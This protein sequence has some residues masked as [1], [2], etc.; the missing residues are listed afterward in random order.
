MTFDKPTDAVTRRHT[1]R[2]LGALCV[3]GSVA[4]CAGQPDDVNKAATDP[5]AAPVQPPS[6]ATIARYQTIQDNGYTIDAV[7][8]GYLTG[9][10]PRTLVYYNG[11]EPVGNIVIDP[12]ARRL[13]LVLDG[14]V[15]IRYGCAV[16]KE[17]KTFSGNGVIQRKAEWPHWR[18]TASMIKNEPDKYGDY[19]EGVDGGPENPLGARA[20]YLYRNG[21]DTYYRIHGTNNPS[22]IGRA[23]SAGCIR[24]FD[25]DIIDLYSRVPLGTKVHVRT[26]EESAQMVGPLQPGF[27]GYVVPVHDPDQVITGPQA[28][29]ILDNSSTATDAAVASTDPSEGGG[30]S[31]IPPRKQAI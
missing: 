31:P 10:N 27:M 25:Q 30:L 19:A 18:P 5:T 7:D 29:R 26:P 1:L 28:D 15:A 8:P 6:A 23:T 21:R 20:L 2:V 24:L 13:Y 16:G 4:A 14:G 12:Y 17:G 3:T 11:P 9:S 22:T